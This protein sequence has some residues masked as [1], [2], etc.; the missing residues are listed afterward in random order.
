M[1]A[2]RVPL[3]IQNGQKLLR[4][5]RKLNLTAAIQRHAPRPDMRGWAICAGCR[6]SCTGSYVGNPGCHRCGIVGSC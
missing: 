3:Y 2:P 5:V 4:Y 6:Q 1:T